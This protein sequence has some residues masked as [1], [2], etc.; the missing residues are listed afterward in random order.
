MAEES[1]EKDHGKEDTDPDKAA[2]ESASSEKKAEEVAV[3]DESILSFGGLLS[4]SSRVLL[5]LPGP[6]N[7]GRKHGTPKCVECLS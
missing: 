4:M 2:S 7:G 3:I 5:S 6:H 1:I